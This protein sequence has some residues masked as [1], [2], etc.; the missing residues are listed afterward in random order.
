VK[1]RA[2]ECFLETAKIAYKGRKIKFNYLQPDG[3][4]KLMEID[5][6]EFA[7]CDYGLVVDTSNDV[8][9]LMQNLGQLAQAGLQNDKMNF[10]TLIK[11]FLTKS[12]VEKQRLIERYEQRVEEQ[13]RQAQQQQQ[14]Q[15]EQQLQQNAQLEQAKMDREYQMHQEKLQTQ[16]LTAQINSRAE[17]LRMSIMNHDN[18]EA[19]TIEREKMVEEARQFDARLKL[20]TQKQKDDARLKEKQIQATKQ[21]SISK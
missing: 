14:Q 16:I 19:N 9:E 18:D 15:F 10:S 11:I 12:P 13:Q 1:K 8:Q 20:D 7:E 2:I 3:S 21:K 5:G 17:E 6:D 4:R